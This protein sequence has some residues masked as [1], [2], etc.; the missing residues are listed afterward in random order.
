MTTSNP[1]SGAPSTVPGAPSR[2]P[3]APSS[4]PGSPGRLPSVAAPSSVTRGDVTLSNGATTV[5]FKGVAQMLS[6][7]IGYSTRLDRLRQD[8]VKKLAQDMEAWAKANAPWEDQTGAARASLRG[9]WQETGP[10][11]ST[12]AISHGVAYGM[13]L[14]TMQGGILQIIVPTILHF[15]SEVAAD[16]LELSTS[17]DHG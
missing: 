16:E 17:L 11:S 8:L 12:A 6:R 1:F 4:V 5:S 10:H 7:A 14:E 15:A 2:V 13:Y 9:T 3:G